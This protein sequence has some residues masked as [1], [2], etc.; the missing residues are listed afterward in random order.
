MTGLSEK[1]SGQQHKDR[2]FLL[3]T[4]SYIFRAYHALP[5]MTNRA[6][7]STHAV[8][9]MNNMLRKLLAAY[10][11]EYVAAAFDLE[12]PTFRHE[13]F[14]DYK[15]NRAEMP[16]D[17]AEQ[18]PYIRELLEG[19]RIPEV[20]RSGYEADDI[21]GTLARRAAAEGLEVLIITSDKDM[22]QL[23]GERV[24]VI[25]PMKNDLVYDP[26]KVAEKMGVRPEQIPDLLALQGDSVDN[27]PGAPGIGEK[28]ARELIQQYGN[29]QA[30]L[31][32]AAEVK[33][34]T[35]RESLQ[36]NVEQIRMNRQ[37]ATIDEA[38]PVEVDL[39]SLRHRKSDVERL[40]TLFQ[41]LGFTTLLKDLPPPE[42][43]PTDY[44]VLEDEASVRT[45]LESLPAEKVVAVAIRAG[46]GEARPEMLS[47]GLQ[48]HREVALSPSEGA[49]RS[50]PHEFFPLLKEWLEDATAK[51]AIHDSKAARLALAESGAGLSGVVHDTFLYAALLDATD[52]RQDLATVVERRFGERSGGENAEAAEAA[53]WTGRLV[54]LLEPE[55]RAER[56]QKV[57]EDVELPLAPILAGME[58]AGILIDAEELKKLS[59]RLETELD[60]LRAAI[61]RLTGEEFNINSPKQLG[62]VLYK[63]MGLPAP[64][65]R[66]KTKALSTAV[67]VLEELAEEHE[68]PRRVLE[69]RQLTKLKSTYI[70][71]L[72]QLRNP[73]TGR[74]HTSYNQAGTATGR[75]SSSNPN[76]QNIPIRT[77]LGRQIRAAFVADKGHRLL[78]AD[79]SQ[80]EL[81]LLA[82][83]SEDPLLVEAFRRNEDIHELTARAV[84]G[85]APEEQTSEH[86]RRAKAVNYGIVYG[87]SAF[88]LA[89]QL[90]I[91]QEEAQQFIDDYFNRYEGVRN[92]RDRVLEQV[93]GTAQVRTLSG[94]MRRI[95]DINAKDGNARHF[96][97]RTAINTP[98]QGSASDLIKLAMIHIHRALGER[99]M[100]SRMILQVHDEVVLEVPQAES[101]EA[102]ALVRDGM[103]HAY[104][105][106]VPLQTYIAMGANWRDMEEI[107]EREE[108]K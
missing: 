63:K 92:Y 88:G 19:L 1:K 41:E 57:Y 73:A 89:R 22:L 27:I 49:A 66:G 100:E 68:A 83:F 71:T 16:D 56:L 106:R 78:A 103:D 29:V 40:R 7:L 101:A 17:L 65:R 97:E 96:A 52:S 87:I 36:L 102:V 61:Y 94:R 12:G 14:A 55:I 64:R 85:V 24:R 26:E 43:A 5:R 35:Y 69:Y 44:A 53:D 38:V 50:V 3:D 21:I 9:G 6:G 47:L 82:H 91:G 75:L 39:D 81:R 105:L 42:S 59:A 95:P 23:V 70:D 67:D 37:L 32:H 51:K 48:H 33:R 11:P 30:C 8:Y 54:A 108:V 104:E 107:E 60:E 76:M 77:E 4:M 10:E 86:R 34:K 98:L 79:Y 58:R 99:G 13:A 90:G 2:I 28:G 72:P 45:Y 18:I 15:A 93:R 84:F 62:Q 46:N 74:I 25:N 20:S 80:I 31:E